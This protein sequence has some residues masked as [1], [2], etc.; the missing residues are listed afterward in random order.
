M[1]LPTSRRVPIIEW[2][3]K[4]IEH[5]FMSPFVWVL[6]PLAA[7]LAGAFKEWLKFKEKQH[8][9]GDSTA[10]L[11]QEVAELKALVKETTVDRN[12]LITRIQNLETIV[13]SQVWDVL[14]DDTTSPEEKKLEVD[15]IKPRIEL[16]LPEEE[17]TR[18]AAQIARRI[19]T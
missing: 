15:A 8:Q 18:K 6:I 9:L 16:P 4:E 12:T 1:Q 5:M 2:I 10:S 11:E 13:T 7:I 19:R 3:H 14:Q 17:S